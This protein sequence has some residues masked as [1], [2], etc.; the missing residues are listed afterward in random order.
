MRASWTTGY[1]GRHGLDPGVDAVAVGDHDLDQPASVG[2]G[3]WT[4]VPSPSRRAST[5]VAVR[6]P[7]SASNTAARAT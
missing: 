3:P 1:V 7:N 6:S 4:D 5:A 2:G